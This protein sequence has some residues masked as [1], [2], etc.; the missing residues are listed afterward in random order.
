MAR[1]RTE[2]G[3]SGSSARGESVRF[4]ARWDPSGVV[5][6]KPRY[7]D[8]PLGRMMSVA[9]VR[10]VDVAARAGVGVES[11]RQLAADPSGHPI[12]SFRV[13]LS[14]A[15]AMGCAP[16]EIC[17]LLA[18]RPRSGLLWDLGI[19]QRETIRPARPSSD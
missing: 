3:E 8:S 5:P 7:P 13:L 17:P 10:W 12:G 1:D 15:A 11:L 18:V 4:A 9:G 14:V 6:P 16:A 2:F 19:F